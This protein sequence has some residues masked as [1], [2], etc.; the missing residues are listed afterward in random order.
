M[1]GYAFIV[2]A[3]DSVRNF[4]FHNVPGPNGIRRFVEVGLTTNVAYAEGRARGAMGIDYGEYRPGK[5]A[6]LISNFSNEPIPF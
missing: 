6:L 1:T 2:V 5:N 3:N 4:F